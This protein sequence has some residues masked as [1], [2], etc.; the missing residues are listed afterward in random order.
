MVMNNV[1]SDKTIEM[2]LKIGHFGHF[3]FGKY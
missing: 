3:V 2:K 1:I